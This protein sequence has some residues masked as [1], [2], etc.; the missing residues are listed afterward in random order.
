[1]ALQPENQ[2]SERLR[3]YLASLKHV[4][5]G[6]VTPAEAARYLIDRLAHGGEVDLFP[7]LCDLLPEA[8][9]TEVHKYLVELASTGFT[10][11][12]RGVGESPTSEEA[13]LKDQER[14]RNSYARLGDLAGVV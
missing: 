5:K 13:L 9:K 8:I 11:Y 12:T 1:M 6:Y 10:R 7:S 14:V 2:M 3:P 4:N